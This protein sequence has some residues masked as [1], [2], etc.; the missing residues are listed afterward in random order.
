MLKRYLFINQSGDC[1]KRRKLFLKCIFIHFQVFCIIRKPA[2]C[3]WDLTKLKNTFYFNLIA[4]A[5][6][7]GRFIMF[8]QIEK[9]IFVYN[10][11][12]RIQNEQSSFHLNVNFCV[13]N[14]FTSVQWSSGFFECLNLFCYYSLP[15]FPGLSRYFSSI[16][17]EPLFPWFP[18]F[19]HTYGTT[20]LSDVFSLTLTI[21]MNSNVCKLW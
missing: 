1:K 14:H 3:P 16:Q 10:H 9:H 5:T 7:H 4:Y 12:C 6:L 18:F 17:F 2:I 21:D 20:W 8:A 15:L 13:I 19:K 11:A